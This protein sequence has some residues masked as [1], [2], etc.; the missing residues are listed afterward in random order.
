[1]SAHRA[2]ETHKLLQQQRR[3][4]TWLRELASQMRS[5]DPQM[6][7]KA[8]RKVTSNSGPA[9]KYCTD[10]KTLKNGGSVDLRDQ[11]NTQLSIPEVQ[12]TR[13]VAAWQ[14]AK[15][16]RNT[17]TT[18]D[19]KRKREEKAEAEA[20]AKAEAKEEAELA[21]KAKEKTNPNANAE[22]GARSAAAATTTSGAASAAAATTTSGAASAAAA[23]T[24]SGAAPA[25]GG[26]AA[27]SDAA[28]AATSQDVLGSP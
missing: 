8:G 2:N 5:S 23:T 13:A 3:R 21:A 17:Q 10:I 12:W 6:H 27:S 4:A 16:A 11:S 20:K 1:L 15:V 19:R 22:A 26:V 9:L 24:T 18:Q 28:T 7:R 25:V 14:S